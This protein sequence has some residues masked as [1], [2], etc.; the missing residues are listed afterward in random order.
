MFCAPR[1]LRIE[2]FLHFAIM[3]RSCLDRRSVKT[4]IVDNT[5]PSSAD[6][7]SAKIRNQFPVDVIVLPLDRGLKTYVALYN[8]IEGTAP[9][10]DQ[11]LMNRR[12]DLLL[13]FQHVRSPN[14]HLAA[15][16]FLSSWRP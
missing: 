7:T 3:V 9:K 4:T 1:E 13:G 11:N 6:K 14:W 2:S 12:A 16:D 8:L 15:E 10:S 5:F